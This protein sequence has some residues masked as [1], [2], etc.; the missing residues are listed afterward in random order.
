MR[1]VRLQGSG[2]S[3]VPV[4]EDVPEPAAP[5]GTRLLLR[6]EASSINGTDLGMLGSGLTAAVIRRAGEP[7]FDVAG[8]VLA[9]GPEVTAF[10]P[11]DRVMALLGHSGGGQAERVPVGQDQA[12]RVPVS[13]SMVDAAALPLAGLTALQALYGRAALRARDSPRVLVVGASGGIGSHAV[14]LARLAGAHVT[15]AARGSALDFV[16][17]LGA[18]DVVDRRER[19]LTALGRRWDV[20]LDTSA[21]LSF[22]EAGSLVEPGGVFVTTRGVGPDVRHELLPRALRGHRPS[23]AAVRTRPRSADLAHLAALVD[24]GRLRTVVDRAYDLDRI[25][26]AYR[27]ANG[28]VTGKVVVTT[29]AAPPG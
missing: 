15:G 20:V 9:C 22:R 3:T 12:A 24:T 18:D 1:A 17:G 19:P 6:V 10:S 11:G 8:E 28:G 2:G 29:A 16:T 26:E 13:C 25:A 14:Q 23:F 5:A 21:R 7:G 27:H 4:V